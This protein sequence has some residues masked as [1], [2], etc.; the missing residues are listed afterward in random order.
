M[1]VWASDRS[2]DWGKRFESSR[3]AAVSALSRRDIFAVLSMV[4]DRL[5]TLRN[6]IFLGGA[7][8]PSGFGRN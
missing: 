6:Q 7:T 4:C 2:G 8:Y 1:S 3:R 5:Y